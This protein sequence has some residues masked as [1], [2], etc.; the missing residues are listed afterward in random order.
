MDGVPLAIN[1]TAEHLALAG[2]DQLVVRFAA[3]A[4]VRM[5]DLTIASEAGVAYA[6]EAVSYDP[7]TFTATW[8]LD[9]PV[10]VDRVQFSLSNAGAGVWSKSVNVLPGDFD[11]TGVV[12]WADVVLAVRAMFGGNSSV[13]AMSDLNGDGAFN[14]RDMIAL[15]DRLGTSLPAATPSA[16]ASDAVTVRATVTR[17]VKASPAG[18]LVAR[19]RVVR[20]AAVDA[21]LASWA[22]ENGLESLRA[23]RIRRKDGVQRITAR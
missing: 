18:P 13:A 23:Q 3:G 2:V 17:F 6:I 21:T 22:S 19:R 15:R 4:Q 12:D 14:L 20:P 9:R 5:E 10:D 1:Q 7:A 16:A 8:T 11:A